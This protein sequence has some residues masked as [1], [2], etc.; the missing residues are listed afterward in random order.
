[1][2]A[3]VVDDELRAARDL[4]AQEF[5]AASSV[6]QLNA[7]QPLPNSHGD[8]QQMLT[9]PYPDIPHFIGKSLGLEVWM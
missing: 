9:F 7:H 8:H 3:F 4:T 5:L 1:V 6:D 2:R